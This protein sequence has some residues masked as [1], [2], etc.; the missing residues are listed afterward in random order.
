MNFHRVVVSFALALLLLSSGCLPKKNLVLQ[1]KLRDLPQSLPHGAITTVGDDV[2][3][4]YGMNVVDHHGLR[5]QSSRTMTIIREDG[6]LTLV[7]SI[8]LDDKSLR[9]LEKLGR[10]KNIIR[11]GAFHGRDDAFYQHVYGAQLWAY[12]EMSFS[13]GEHLDHDLASDSLPL[14]RAKIID[15]PSTKHKEA[16]LLL[17]RDGGILISCDSIKNWQE[18]DQY[19]SDEI[20]KMMNEGHLIGPAKIDSTWLRAMQPAKTDLLALKDISFTILITAHG[21]PLTHNARET[22]SSSIAEAIKFIDAH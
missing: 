13:H 19:F 8:R 17:E 6:D 21:K 1:E 22:L 10:I 12:A 15:L 20:Y 4:V 3:V 18:K 2:F 16:L 5:I 9:A 11:L 14:R 7:N